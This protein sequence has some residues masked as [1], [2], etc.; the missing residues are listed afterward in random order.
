M[1]E[2]IF[3]DIGDCITSKTTVLIDGGYFHTACKKL[4]INVDYK[5]LRNMF[6]S[7]FDIIRINYLVTLPD[8]DEELSVI[9]L[10]DWLQFNGYDLHTKW[11][12]ESVDSDSF[13]TNV[14]I[15]LTIAAL[16]AA[17]KAD[18]IIISSGSGA[19]VP[20]VE[21]LKRMNVTVCLLGSLEK[22]V[23]SELRRKADLYMDIISIKN[24]I[25]NTRDS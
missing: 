16:V 7:Q 5:K 3:P 15:E 17:R 24:Y 20:L 9:K 13:S 23:D 19:L 11:I 1:A 4:G 21:E 2:Y 6:I 12:K 10:Y 18:K 22:G 25:D 8:T 14:D